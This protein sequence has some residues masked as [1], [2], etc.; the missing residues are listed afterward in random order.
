MQ[1]L[2][3]MNIQMRIITEKNIDQLESLSY[4]NNINKLFY[5]NDIQPNDIINANKEI[6]QNNNDG[7]ITVS[8]V[9]RDY[10][11]VAA[12]SNIQEENM[13][14]QDVR[15]I[16]DDPFL[17]SQ[18]VDPFDDKPVQTIESDDPFADVIQEVSLSDFGKNN[19]SV[20]PQ[21]PA[22]SPQY[23]ATSPQYPAT[24]PQYPA[25]SPQYPATSPEGID[26]TQIKQPETDEKPLVKATI[27]VPVGQ[28]VTLTS[29]DEATQQVSEPTTTQEVKPNITPPISIEEEK[30]KQ[31]P[32]LEKEKSVTTDEPQE[33]SDVK[34]ITINKQS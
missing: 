5:D 33:E 17:P 7:T 15:Q 26:T 13:P 27:E 30:E 12:P 9:K 3:T 22:T 25:T 34:T 16:A 4:S 31:S 21:Y 8:S 20:S 10:T 18:D 2:Q 23:P 19:P 1:E 6:L 24:S 29:G 11:N 32:Q 14:I 28:K